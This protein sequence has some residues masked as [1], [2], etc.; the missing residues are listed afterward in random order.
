MADSAHGGACAMSM[1]PERHHRVSTCQQKDGIS[2][3]AHRREAIRTALARGSAG[4]VPAAPSV[5]LRCSE[6]AFRE[7]RSGHEAGSPPIV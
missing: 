7:D 4:W 2:E 5:M 6:Y 1:I 3:T